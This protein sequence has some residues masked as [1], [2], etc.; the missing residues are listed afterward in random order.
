VNDRSLGLKVR[1][2][3]EVTSVENISGNM[4]NVSHVE[5]QRVENMNMIMNSLI[6]I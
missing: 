4:N 1:C 2:N 5:I 3:A 6:T